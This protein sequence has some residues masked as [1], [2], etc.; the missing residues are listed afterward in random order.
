MVYKWWKVDKGGDN[1]LN[2]WITLKNQVNI[3]KFRLC[4]SA[5]INIQ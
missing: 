5:N 4:S 3:N 1:S 2:L